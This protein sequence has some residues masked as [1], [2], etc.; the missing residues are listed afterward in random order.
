MLELAR[1]YIRNCGGSSRRRLLTVGGVGMLGLSLADA[2]RAEAAEPARTA[3]RRPTACIF[4]WLDGGPSQ[5]ETFDPKPEAPAE[6]R[7]PYGAIETN[8][9]GIRISELL[10]TL[11]R[12]MDKFCVIRTLTHSLDR[13]SPI[14]VM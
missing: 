5:F 3:E 6:I 11:A 10:P 2:L 14:H 12:Q 8:V 9:S 4:V 13:H 7:G 1:G